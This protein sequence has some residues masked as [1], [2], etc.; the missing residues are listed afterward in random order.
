MVTP[1][2][3]CGAAYTPTELK[4]PY[5]AVSGA[6]PIKKASEHFFFRLSDERCADFLRRWTREGII[7]SC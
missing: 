5:S 4:N 7:Y 3:A 1:C 6:T 2:E